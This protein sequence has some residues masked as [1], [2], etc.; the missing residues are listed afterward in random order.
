[1]ALTVMLSCNRC[2]EE[3]DDPTN[4]ECPNYDP[5]IAWN[6]QSQEI[7]IIASGYE[8]LD[9]DTIWCLSQMSFEL[10]IA[11]DSAKWTIGNDPTVHESNSLSYYFGAPYDNVEIKCISYRKDEFNCTGNPVKIDTLIKTVK[12]VHWPDLPI[13]TWEFDGAFEDAPNDIKHIS[14]NIEVDPDSPPILPQGEQYILGLIDTCTIGSGCQGISIQGFNHRKVTPGTACCPPGMASGSGFVSLN[15]QEI[16]FKYYTTLG[17][18][19]FRGQRT[20]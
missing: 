13:W 5:C 9:H 19:T 18:K 3:C 8:A 14:F 6:A 17:W 15:K 20:N 11:P 4:P 1:M 2:K 10:A 7:K 16:E 12:L